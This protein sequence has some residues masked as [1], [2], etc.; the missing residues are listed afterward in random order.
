MC[1]QCFTILN[2]AEYTIH[3]D[4]DI[5]Q[6]TDLSYSPR[7]LFA[8]LRI[9]NHFVFEGGDGFLEFVQLPHLSCDGVR[10]FHVL[11][12]QCFKLDL[13]PFGVG[14]VSL[15]FPLELWPQVV[16]NVFSMSPQ[17]MCVLQV[18]WNRHTCQTG[19]PKEHFL[20]PTFHLPLVFILTAKTG[21]LF[22]TYNSRPTLKQL[23]RPSSNFKCLAVYM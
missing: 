21:P 15:A 1:E 11:L 7:L 9:E 6:M 19:T 17:S 23:Q 13:P 16:Q 3:R 2:I 14:I 10:G 12:L 5:R 4:R 8:L 22:V 18:L 20:M